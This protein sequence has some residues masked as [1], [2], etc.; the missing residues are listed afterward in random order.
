[1]IAKEPSVKE[2]HKLLKTGK[3]KLR[4]LEYINKKAKQKGY[5]KNY[6]RDWFDFSRF[7]KNR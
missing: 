5:N 3:V 6:I 1:M 7:W 2:I 4:S